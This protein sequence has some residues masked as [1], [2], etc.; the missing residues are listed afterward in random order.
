MC[1]VSGNSDPVND[2]HD[3]VTQPDRGHIAEPTPTPSFHLQTTVTA[4]NFGLSAVFT[5]TV[6]VTSG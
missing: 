1:S 4:Y 5:L 3:P 6:E 2:R